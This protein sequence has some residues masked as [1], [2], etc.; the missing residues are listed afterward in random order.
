MNAVLACWGKPHAH[1]GIGIRRLT[2]TI[3]ECRVGLD[4]GLAIVFVVTPPEL[5]FLFLGS[6]DQVQKLIRSANG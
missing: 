5:V 4:E 1:S 6:H 2:K 3:H